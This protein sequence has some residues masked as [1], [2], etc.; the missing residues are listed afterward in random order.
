MKMFDHAGVEELKLENCGRVGFDFVG[1]GGLGGSDVIPGL[2][3]L[4]PSSGHVPA[5]SDITL[6]VRYLP[7]VPEKF[8]KSFEVG[9]SYGICKETHVAI[10]GGFFIS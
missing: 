6:R 3:V 8:H 7:G 5:F 1:L 9:L 10:S 4:Y 2:P